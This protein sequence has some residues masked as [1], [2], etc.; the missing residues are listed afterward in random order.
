MQKHIAIRPHEN[1]IVATTLCPL[2]ARAREKSGSII[3]APTNEKE[4][5]M[6]RGMGLRPL[7]NSKLL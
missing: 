1:S 3:A 5:R 7:K 6:A 4:V 2:R